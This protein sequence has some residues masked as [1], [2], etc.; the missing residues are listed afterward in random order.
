MISWGAAG[1]FVVVSSAYSAS[2]H[3]TILNPERTN[4]HD[5]SHEQTGV[6]ATVIAMGHKG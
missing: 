3:E 2:H 6:P 4:Y 1:R 5:R